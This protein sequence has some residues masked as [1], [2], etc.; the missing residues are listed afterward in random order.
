VPLIIRCKICADGDC[1]NPA[2]KVTKSLVKEIKNKLAKITP[3]SPEAQRLANMLISLYDVANSRTAGLTNHLNVEI[4]RGGM[5]KEAKDS[6][7]AL[8]EKS[9]TDSK[10]K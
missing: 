7:F 9:L 8:R 5:K 4:K 6:L 10:I 1:D 2:E 3:K